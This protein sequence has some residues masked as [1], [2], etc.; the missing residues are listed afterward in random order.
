M[1]LQTTLSQNITPKR[2]TLRLQLILLAVLSATVCSGCASS[3]FYAA[4][5]PQEYRIPTAQ[6]IQGIDL[7]RLSVSSGTSSL[8]GP[9]DVL[10]ITMTSG[11]E[12]SDSST[13]NIRVNENGKAN[14]P[15]IGE[16]A[17]ESLEPDEAERIIAA[18]SIERGIFRQPTV[19][20]MVKRKFVNKITV[21]GAVE[22]PGIVELDRSNSD[23]LGAIAKAGGLTEE[24]SVEIQIHRKRKS[25]A[26]ITPK[27]SPNGVSLTSFSGPG[28]E[29]PSMLPDET[30]PVSEKINLAEAVKNGL[31]NF[32]LSDGDVVMVYEEEPRIVH[33]LGLV[34]R[35]QQIIIPHNQDMRVLDALA[36]AGGRTMGIADTVHVIRHVPDKSKPIVIEVSVREAKKNGDAN[37]VLAP[38]DVISVEETPVTFVLGTLQ[39]LV[40]F[41]ISGTTTIF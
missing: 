8:I 23:I 11:Y 26:Q 21:V 25:F 28:L 38:H 41:G 3:I 36:T 19:T 17:L 33:V 1:T 2:I 10:E 37:L 34:N 40:R 27:K 30:A 20:V 39:G 6:N 12:K 22:K 5:L 14:I 4:S 16:V 32:A 29:N 31:G 24:A 7:T 18:V 15:L 35:P 9:G 13:I